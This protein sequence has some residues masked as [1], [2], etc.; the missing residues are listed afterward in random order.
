MW[1]IVCTDIVPLV[2]GHISQER[3]S[4]LKRMIWERRSKIVRKQSVFEKLFH[5]L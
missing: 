1:W 4:S 2:E 5:K 3:M